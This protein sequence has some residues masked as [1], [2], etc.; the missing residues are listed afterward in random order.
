MR[1]ISSLHCAARFYSTFLATLG[2]IWVIF[3]ARFISNGASDGDVAI[4]TISWKRD[5]NTARPPSVAGPGI[6]SPRSLNYASRSVNSAR[7][8]SFIPIRFHNNS[9]S[10]N[11][12][13]LQVEAFAKR[14]SRSERK[15]IFIL[16]LVRLLAKG[17]RS[18]TRRT[19]QQS[20]HSKTSR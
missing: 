10:W 19:F 3:C 6:V 7:N 12:N 8:C 5:T 16:I 1:A 20:L 17:E 2:M 15:Y 4:A 11:W 14:Q 9:A 13:H 18:E